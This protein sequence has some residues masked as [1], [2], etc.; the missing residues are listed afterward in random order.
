MDLINFKIDGIIQK[1]FHIE[2]LLEKILA[3]L[4]KKSDQILEWNFQNRT[5]VLNHGDAIK[6]TKTENEII[7]LL[8]NSKGNSIL[9]VDIFKALWPKETASKNTL[10][11]HIY[12]LKKKIPILENT[13]ICIHGDG[14]YLDRSIINSSKIIS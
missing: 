10:D 1:P 5:V 7:H 3:A 11:T 8:F 9:R 12:N 13:L 6:L 4:G 2:C 14:Y